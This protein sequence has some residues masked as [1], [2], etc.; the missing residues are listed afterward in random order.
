[1]LKYSNDFNN[2]DGFYWDLSHEVQEVETFTLRPIIE[3][4][5]NIPQNTFSEIFDL[6]PILLVVLISFIGMRKGINFIFNS[7]R[8]S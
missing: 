6:L 1:M 5:E 4:Q 3:K 7:L 8:N 2:I